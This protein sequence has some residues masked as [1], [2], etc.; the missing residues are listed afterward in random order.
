MPASEGLLTHRDS[1]AFG[2]GE[3]PTVEDQAAI[4]FG[5]GSR[6]WVMDALRGQK[7]LNGGKMSVRL[8]A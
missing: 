4:E 1:L 6:R 5:T 3:M 2:F 7:I 8:T